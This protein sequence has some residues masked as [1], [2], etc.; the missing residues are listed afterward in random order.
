MRGDRTSANVADLAGIALDSAGNLYI[1]SNGGIR[2][3][4]NGVITDFP[5]YYYA[6]DGLSTPA[7]AA[8]DS[9]GNLYIA[10]PNSNRIFKVSNG[11]TTT[12]AGTGVL[13]FHGDNGPATSAQL[14]AP[15]G[16]AVDVAWNLYIA[17]T[18]NQ[19]IRKV[20]N[21]VI[22]TVA[23]GGPTP[24]GLGD[25]EPATSALLNF[26]FGVDL[27]AAGNLYIEDTLD[28]RIRKV[29]NGVITTV[30]GGGSNSV[31]LAFGSQAVWYR[32]GSG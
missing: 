5:G 4:S 18:G 32:F 13:G 29:S 3:V 21:G 31:L 14:T 25:N 8:V 2:K 6:E 7:A 11:A 12:V 30:A 1:F 9:A 28:K 15:R 23:G 19:R 20:S 10:D 24:G 27:D 22:T 17:D 26:P 16:V